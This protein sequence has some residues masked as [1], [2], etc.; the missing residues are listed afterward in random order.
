MSAKMGTM[1]PRQPLRPDVEPMRVWRV[2]RRMTQQ[3]LADAAGVS[4]QTISNLERGATSPLNNLVRE[5]IADALEIP[6]EY[7]EELRRSV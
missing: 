3:D 7:V 2:R 1:P 6:A 5:A 4:R